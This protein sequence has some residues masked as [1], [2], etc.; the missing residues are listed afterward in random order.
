MNYFESHQMTKKILKKKT[1][2]KTQFIILMTRLFFLSF[3][4]VCC[5]RKALTAVEFR[6][7]IIHGRIKQNPIF[8]NE[9]YKNTN[10]RRESEKKWINKKKVKKAARTSRKTMHSQKKN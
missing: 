2:P 4:S 6:K 8:L 5:D 1:K 3:H 9:K 7:N 10:T